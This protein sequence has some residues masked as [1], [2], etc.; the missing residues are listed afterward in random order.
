MVKHPVDG[1]AD[2]AAWVL[3]DLGLCTKAVGD[4]GARMIC[5]LCRVGNHVAVVWN[6]VDQILR[7]RAIT[8]MAG[9]DREP[10]RQA[11]SIDCRM[12]SGRQAAPGTADTGSF[13]PA[14]GEAASAWLLQM[15]G[16]TRTYSKSGP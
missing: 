4:A 16:S 15:V 3:L 8:P 5:V 7:L 14:I 2:C 13:K 1:I 11:G 6:S 12:E 10:D 9:R